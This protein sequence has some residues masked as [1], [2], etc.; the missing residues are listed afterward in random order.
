[1]I[2]GDCAMPRWQRGWRSRGSKGNATLPEDPKPTWIV[3]R[4]NSTLAISFSS[5]AIQS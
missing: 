4:M 1:M 3:R 5:L 2:A